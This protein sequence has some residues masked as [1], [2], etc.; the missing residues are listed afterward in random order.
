MNYTNRYFVL[1]LL[2]AVAFLFIVA[3]P[4][5]AAV[6]GT[7]TAITSNALNTLSANTRAA[8]LNLDLSANGTPQEA[9]NS[10]TVT[11]ATSSVATSTP[12]STS[13]L[14]FLGVAKDVNAN[15]I[16][17]G[18]DTVL[19]TS[20][21]AGINATTTVNI[22]AATSTPAN[23][24]FFV[25]LQTSATS[26]F[27]DNGAPENGAAVAQKFVVRIS[28]S[29]GVVAS[30][31]NAS[32]TGATS[33]AVF[34]ADIHSQ[35]PVPGAITPHFD[36]SNSTY[37]ISSSGGAGELGVVY[38]YAT[39]TVGATPIATSSVNQSGVFSASLGAT[40]R[41]SIW[42]DATDVAGNATS[43][44]AQFNLSAYKPTV[45][46]L[47]VFTDRIIMQVTKPLRGDQASICSNYLVNG[48]APNCSNS[49]G[50]PYIEF[51]GNQVVLKNLSLSGTASFS[52]NGLIQDTNA[53]QFPLSFST[54]S[55]AV[56]TVS[57]PTVSGVTPSSGQAG[58]TVTIAGTNF[59]TATGT[60]YFSGGFDPTTGP[61]QPVEA[62]TTAWSNTSIT[63][64]VPTGAQGGPVQVITSGGM[65]SDVNQNTFFD[66][67]GNAYFKLALATS[68]APIATSTNM[69]IFVGD[70]NGEHV[71]Y[72]GDA[73][74]TSF[75][76]TTY[77][78]TIPNISGNGFVWAYDAS[79]TNL[80]APGTQ[81]Q[82]GT[83]SSTPQT[84]VLASSTPYSVSGTITLGTSCIAAYKNQNVA[85]MAIPQ[86]AS[87]A[88]GPGGV[89]P[90]FFTTD[91]ACQTSYA[92]ALPGAGTYDVEAHL[93]PSTSAGGLLD[94]AGQTAVI[95]GGTPTATANFTFTT[96]AHSIYG[97]VVGGD[98]A[99]LTA[100]KYNN[101][102][103]F[104]Y[105]PI[106]GG[107]GGAARPDTSGYFR[108]YAA[109]GAYKLSVGGPAM[110][111]GIEQDVLVTTS[112]SFAADAS[113]PVVTIKL[114]PPTSYIEGYVKD[115][116]NNAIASA[117]VF[118]YCANGPGGGRGTTDSQ[119][120]YKMFVPPCSNYHVSGFSPQY[121]QFTEQ[122][123]IAI[124]NAASTA[125]VNFTLSSSDFV[126]VSGTVSKNS[127]PVA[128]ANVWITQGTFGG[129]V[130]GGQT[131]A[132]GA[133]SLKVRTGLS[134]LYVHAAV[135]G[136]GELASAA[137][138]NGG[139]VSSNQTG[140]SLSSSVATLTIQLKPG[141]TF[142]Q[143][144]LGAHSASGGGYT[145]TATATSTDHDTYQISVPYA[146][147]GTLY[148]ID[149]GIPNFGP[150]PATSTT[151]TGNATIII[152]LSSINYYTV[153][154][155]VTGDF[156]GA[157]VW[158]GGVNGGGGTQVSSSTGAFS[159]TL[160]QGTY[161]IGVNKP[162]Y[163]GSLLAS[164]NIS[165]TT[166]GLSLSLTQSTST[167]S[168]TV[169]YNGTAVDGVRVWADNASGG[170]A[171]G[172]TDA[173]GAFSLSVS[174]GSWRIHALADGYE[175][176]SPLLVTAPASGL[177][178]NLSA[179]NFTPAQQL[180]SISPSAGGIVQTSSTL[181]QIPQG[182]LGSGSTNVQL[183]VADTMSTPSKKGAKVI[184]NGKNISASY[185]SGASQGQAITTL[186]GN[187]TLQFVLTKAEL[188]AD[189]IT[190]LTAAQKMQIGYDD[191]T[192]N[193]WTYIPTT[194]TAS[195][196]DGT[197]N[198][199]ESITLSGTTSHLSTYAPVSPTSGSAPNTPTGVSA[200]AGNGQVTL[201]WDAVSGA[202]KYDVYKQSGSEYVYLAQTTSLSSTETGLTNGTTYYYKVSALDDSD[203]ESAA[204][205]AVSAT[206]SAPSSGGGGGGGAAPAPYFT[207]QNGAS[208]VSNPDVMLEMFVPSDIHTMSFATSSS[209]LS[210]SS[211]VPYA[212]QYAWNLCG[213][214]GTPCAPGVY[215]VYGRFFTTTG[216]PVYDATRSVTLVASATSSPAALPSV[217]TPASAGTVPASFAS[218][219]ELQAVFTYPLMRGVRGNAVTRLQE[220]LSEDRTL[221]PEGSITGY[222]GPLTERAVQ[223]FQK[224]YGIVVSGNPSTTGYGRVG[225]ATRAKL[226]EVFGAGS[227][228][229]APLIREPMP[230]AA[231]IQELETKIQ[232]L[233][234]QVLQL[235][236]QLTD[237]LK[238]HTGGY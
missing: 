183:S 125:T 199:L 161:D 165:T 18:T 80:P 8:V 150:I 184:G 187:I 66:I 180:Q 7:S 126:T 6:V 236:Q 39:S 145:N 36:S 119:G 9:F 164:Q 55:V 107:Q 19:A 171:G 166:T 223:R 228:S 102:W 118:S 93:P 233:Q 90:A 73:S 134:N 127:T 12:F 193:S 81:L 92:L 31:T 71:Y 160:R 132:N 3:S 208:S 151:V 220:L 135:N 133:F 110:P 84:L 29:T 123:G 170:W 201:S 21:V 162:G 178:L 237:T 114:A 113:T 15:G 86:G 79:G 48:A 78:Y 42:M 143:V 82:S 32:L 67:L 58:N 53:D 35:A 13:S 60:V 72:A 91:T 97:R 22:A 155:S 24:N 112:T 16:F 83:S 57:V 46:S 182:A 175:L 226:I 212:S 139:T 23:G 238:S 192:S 200:S 30:S 147:G 138:A 37:S 186:S 207:V 54:S 217:S 154:G 232:A 85:V 142:S 210:A 14:S 95:T 188:I 105:Q 26:T 146:P 189:G 124:A 56:Q 163:S 218:A 168:G 231:V 77:V 50:A 28:T 177:S 197:W 63:A 20:S 140:I 148:T 179:V 144:F 75:N 156:N 34:T 17:D 209:G 141:N 129:S 11:V 214:A 45:T 106:A 222:F 230:R 221:Y 190:N 49:P 27:T 99:A 103:V 198:T 216:G 40:Y 158:A 59:G 38:V 130:A 4:A 152:D 74:S 76:A 94:P 172:Q 225:P 122:T 52:V 70:K 68:S 44:K 10:V 64:T 196:T 121:G 191:T 65:M 111:S 229:S 116:A 104:A 109:A 157:F 174:P 33:T 51:S 204:S 234:R 235:L 47:G 185:A 153:S 2:G 115:G 203:N 128:S 89:Q 62:S 169:S 137:L 131:D 149:G 224:K 181:V 43:S 173:N 215:T 69:R 213:I 205:A 98:G 167:L 120:Y 211:S 101:L 227:Q 202:T 88:M 87:A 5:H 61:K 1:S 195:S 108:L 194:V 176:L 159:M 100:D 25:F 96:A 117:D 206:P 41:P 219:S 136:Q